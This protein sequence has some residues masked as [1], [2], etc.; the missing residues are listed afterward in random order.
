MA[1]YLIPDDL[2]Q[3]TSLYA[4]TEVGPDITDER[5]EAEIETQQLAI[6][7][8]CGEVFDVRE[9]ETLSLPGTGSPDLLVTGFTLRSV[10]S[11]GLVHLDSTE[12]E[13]DPGTYRVRPW[14][15]ELLNGRKFDRRD[16][17]VLYDAEVG[18][19]DGLADAKRAVALLVFEALTGSNIGRHHAKRWTNGEVWF[20][21]DTN[22]DIPFGLP[23]VDRF[24]RRWRNGQPAVGAI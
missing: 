2:R 20:E 14:G 8:E 16:T 6:E 22:P 1:A 17:V 4:D 3:G 15:V 24:V 18:N 5:V 7:R 10:G 12:S 23:E 11:V 9:V 19:P 13:L 21:I